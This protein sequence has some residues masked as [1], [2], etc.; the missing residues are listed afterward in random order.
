MAEPILPH[1]P[2]EERERRRK[3]TRMLL[4]VLVGACADCDASGLDRDLV[5][6]GDDHLSFF[7]G[8]ELCQRCAASHGIL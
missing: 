4:D 1:H 6:V 8:D 5:P 3:K 7:A 2:P